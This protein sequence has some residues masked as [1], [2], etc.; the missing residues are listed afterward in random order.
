[1]NNNCGIYCITIHDKKYIGS[2][3]NI[4]RRLIQHKSDLINNRHCNK[5]LQNLYNKYS[6]IKFEVLEYLSLDNL[7]ELHI[8]EKEYINLLNAYCNIQDPE[9]NFNIK[10]VFQFSKE[11]KLINCFNSCEEAALHLNIS[12]SNIQHAAQ[13][14]E[15]NTLTAGGYYWSYNKTINLPT[16][17][18]IKPI[19]VY[20]IEGNYLKTYN[21]IKECVND[22]F[23]NRL[24]SSV[25]SIINRITK[26]KT[27]S[28]EGYRFSYYLLEK[29]DNTQLLKIGKNYPIVQLSCN[30]DKVIKVWENIKS[31]SKDLNIPKTYITNAIIHKYRAG[32]YYW[33]RLGT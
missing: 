12:T 18:R 28:L 10:S 20:D 31:A 14:N 7:S 16:D 5:I 3:I 6:N 2:S 8:K 23:P 26:Y 21:S 15:K 25:V 4:K 19:Y 13:V 17:K 1:M 9:T 33:K 24:Y 30:G 32:D 11:G 29:L 27:A 22:L